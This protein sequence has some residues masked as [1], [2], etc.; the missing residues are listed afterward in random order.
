MKKRSTHLSIL[1]SFAIPLALAQGLEAPAEVL[2]NLDFF[3]S[4]D[5]VKNMDAL[6]YS[7]SQEETSDTK[8]KVTNGWEPLK[9]STSTAQKPIP[10]M[11]IS[12]S[13]IQNFPKDKEQT[14]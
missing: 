2:E 7:P 4:Y 8:A 1:L 3:L 13:T 14:P 10:S 5:L 9:V 11:R 6:E 12:T